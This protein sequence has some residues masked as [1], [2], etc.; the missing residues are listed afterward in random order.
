MSGIIFINRNGLRGREISMIFQNPASHLDP[1]MTI[2]DHVAE[3]LRIHF[4][5][6][7]TDAR[8]EALGLLEAVH[9]RDAEA[10][11]KAHRRPVSSEYRRDALQHRRADVGSDRGQR[12]DPDPVS[13]QHE[14]CEPS[15]SE[16][17]TAPF[18]DGH[19]AA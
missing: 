10:R 9:I 13:A 14:L 2:G 12:N 16:G 5:L 15:R 6:N 7:A 18:R 1:L 17:A 19:R 11:M 3:P 8:R 4:G